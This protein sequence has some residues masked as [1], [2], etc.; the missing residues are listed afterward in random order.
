MRARWFGAQAGVVLSEKEQDMIAALNQRLRQREAEISMLREISELV[1]SEHKLQ[2]VFDSVAEHARNLIQAETVAIPVLH[3]DT[4]GYTYRAASGADAAELLNASLPLD[5]GICG[6]VF[7]NRKAWWRGTLDLLE[8]N[9]R[10]RWEREAGTVILVPLVGKRRFLGGIA[11]IN[12]VGGGEFDQRDLDLLSLFAHQVS[13]AIDN[14]MIFEELNAARDGAETLQIELEE[15]NRRLSKTNRELQH[16]A[17]HDPLTGL[18]NRTLIV[19]RVQQAISSA[20]RDNHSMALIMIDLDHFKEV[21]D[22]LGHAVGDDLLVNVGKRFQST[23]REPDTLGRLG[24]DE[25]AVIL[26]NAD[27]DSAIIVANKLQSALNNP[28]EVDQSTFPLG[29]SMGI[30]IY[31][32]NG[33][34]PSTLLKSADVAMYIA[35]R[36][37]DDFCV[38]DPEHDTHHPQRLKLLGDLRAAI[39]QCDIDLA[40]QAKL[41]IHTN[42]VTGIEALARWHH[43]EHGDIPPHDFIPIL[44]QTGLIRAFTL[45]ILD[46]AVRFCKH[47]HEH[48]F[49]LS[50]AVNLS[51][52]NLRDKNLPEQIAGILF[53]HELDAGFLILEITESVIMNDPQHT[54]SILT[55]LGMMGA[56]L[57]IDDFGT[58]YSSLSYL[59]R[60]PVQQ[61]KID[62]SFVRNMIED[63]DDA[64][65]VRSTIELAHNLGLGTVAEGAETDEILKA[66][67]K[68]GCDVVQGHAVSEP[69]YAGQLLDFLKSGRCAVRTRKQ[70]DEAANS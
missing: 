39:Q 4:G 33:T 60:L 14:A 21:N 47:C 54:L 43:P 27:R 52:Q 48:G 56:R 7:R 6:W 11:G 16:L 68:M 51:M 1:G 3:E 19:D 38:Y 42:T 69:L 57:S 55:E 28:I 40:Y 49:E 9:E 5:V 65:I 10:N 59:K 8:E 30:A 34:D 36:N 32:E 50:I 66:L 26:A 58:G 64:V 44:E 2:R 62:R 22:T 63:R 37:R 35:K 61:L 15:S 17:V 25:F 31:P 29:A 67:R 23:L 13:I 53:G 46:R 24:G 18:P 20:R 41:D 70:R 12:K 45:Q